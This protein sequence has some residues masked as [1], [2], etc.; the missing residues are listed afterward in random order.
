MITRSWLRRP[1]ARTAPARY[2]P[3]LE[4]LE[5][6]TLLASYV[7]MNAADLITDIR[8]TNAAGG[9]N[10]IELNAAPSAPY[11]L[12]AVN[13]TTDGANGLPVIAPGN[14]LI[15]FAI[16]GGA[17]I[18]IQRSTA[19]GTPAFRLFDVAAGARLELSGLTLKDGLA[20]GSG[21]SAEGGAIYSRGNLRLSEVTVQNNTAQGVNG[22]TGNDNPINPDGLPGGDA[23]GGGLYVAGG[24]ATL[25][26]D[27]I[28]GNSALGGA[29]G[30]GDVTLWYVA[31]E[32]GY[33]EGSRGGAGGSGYGGGLYVADGIVTLGNDG[34]T[35]TDTISGNSAQGGHG[36]AGTRNYN[37]DPNNDGAA[38][39]GGYGGGF[40]VAGGAVTLTNHTLSGNRAQGG[41]GG[42]LGGKDPFRNFPAGYA[43]NGGS[44]VGGGLD[45]TG[46][47]VA[48]TNDTLRGNSAKG[49]Y[50][51]SGGDGFNAD[52]ERFGANGVGGNG[53]AGAG[54]GLEVAGGTVRSSHD[55]LSG[56]K[57]QGGFGGDGGYDVADYGLSAMGGNGGGG[58]G[59]GL[60]VTGGTV[61][62]SNDTL[63]SN[64]AQGGT[65][66]TGGLGSSIVF[67]GWGRGGAGGQGS[68]GGLHVSQGTVT[69]SND[70]LNSNSAQ[71]GSGGRGALPLVF[72]PGFVLPKHGTGGA[73]GNGGGA[74]GGGLDVA[75]GTVTLSS[76]T[77]SGN[78]AQ[79][80]S[81]G[82]GGHTFST[83][84]TEPSL[85]GD[86]N[87]GGNGG[88]GGGGVG[89]GLD[90]T[91]GTVTLTN[92]TLSGN[93]A[94][95][96]TGGQG[97]FSMGEFG[98]TQTQTGGA[99]GGGGRGVG[100][101]LGVAG[102]AVT[103]TND[104]LSGNS[105]RAGSGGSGGGAGILT[106]SLS[107]IQSSG[108]QV[109]AYIS[110]GTGGAGG[111]AGHTAG[112]GLDGAGGSLTLG[113]TLIAQNTL[114]MGT[115][116]AGGA[117][118]GGAGSF[119]GASGA[120]GNSSGPDV[121]GS[122]TS[123]G[124]NLIGA[125][126]GSNLHDGVNG[127]RVGTSGRAIDPML[128]PLQNNGGPTLTM[129][130]LPNS[131]ALNTG[132]NALIRAGVITD[133]RGSG[134][135]RS[136]GG[137]VD[138]GAFEFQ[139]DPP[140]IARAPDL[141]VKEG[142]TAVNFAG[143]Y[144][145][146]GRD[147]VTVTASL[148]TV[149]QDNRLGGWVW[150]YTP[151]DGPA[152]PTTV[153]IT[154]TDDYGLTA[155]S[156]FLLTVDNVAPTPTITGAPATGHIPEGTAITLGSTVTDPSSVDTAAGFT[157][158][159]SMT[160]NG[161]DVASWSG[162]DFLSFAL[163]DNGTYVVTL[164]ATD[165]DGGV[166]TTRTTITVD[167]VAPT[168][169]V[170]GPTDGVR[171]Q[172]RTFTLTASDPSTFMDQAAGF[173]FAINWGDGSTQTVSGP[174]GTTVSHVYTASGGYTVQVT[175]TDKDQ[176][177]GAAVTA[178]DTI[179]AVALETDP[180]DPSQTAL[181]VGGTTGADTITI[182]PADAHGTL[183]VKIGN[184]DL[185]NFKPTGHLIVY[186][187]AGDDTLKLQPAVINGATVYVTAPALLFGDDGNDT[188]DA[189][190]SSANNVL[191]GGA[192]NDTLRG[193]SGRDLLV[194]GVGADLL[195]GDA[196]DDIL[197]GGTTDDDGN[198][199][200]LSAVMAEWS[201][202]DADDATRV[203]H[204]SGTLRGGLNGATLLTASTV[205][206]DAASDIL[207][208]E[209]GTDWFF[210]LL[211][212]TNQ[213]KVKDQTA[214][215]V[216]TGL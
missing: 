179:T 135:A 109:S 31:Q 7:A 15:I 28:S 216:V 116:G 201:R 48:L 50:G 107:D 192:G 35:N 11:T 27:T 143:F 177:T 199:S 97:G 101:G 154:A 183:D 92:D 20:A 102:G 45:V 21:V 93:S 152:G 111:G 190:D 212:G 120:S 126:T 33:A 112:G 10:T 151:P 32:R 53:G 167:N 40:Y 175:A 78:S 127:N 64:S 91:G 14:H 215:E 185:G 73:G 118:S 145:P 12:T 77:L 71:G 49:G 8:L 81:G 108:G 131:P 98:N 147:T 181:C 66:G 26:L 159:W 124:H 163:D 164:T 3:R 38:G 203:K 138:I 198:L 95:G 103:L 155:T 115:A 176:G 207:L 178:T 211:S 24:T 85:P 86:Y 209:G 202:T 61:L 162:V 141:T 16:F 65:G 129:A 106:R 134:F 121:C 110:G 148:G 68:G 42:D 184:T 210:A 204:L 153:T 41:G 137:T 214:G 43:G 19:P 39:G 132:S 5:A 83:N 30:R 193:G 70:T 188:L 58:Y 156:T 189:S 157:Y 6:R 84:G 208:G 117:G 173:T 172:A 174:S 96:G 57:A 113:N 44:G 104:T 13:N 206:D 74:Q 171:G 79:G 196:G 52:K 123:A 105:A 60:D 140:T 168:A 205:H 90:V 99:G 51:G 9:T 87:A 150:R 136:R 114:T 89:G 94:Q 166:G 17:G 67:F 165:K 200:A 182:K 37:R 62:S 186:G 139:D 197:I 56:N 194:G 133:Q 144:D 125:G 22:L 146:Q 122:V 75:G 4:A 55:T 76:D 180:T 195:R 170:S 59:G 63:S 100:G 47:S 82:D 23:R 72:F 36:G 161:V 69:L 80:G 46:G 142:T 187:Q 25:L 128:G 160:Q 130:L 1:F 29:G 191:E 149:T 54:G 34:T 158:H 18:T 213:D 88:N 169:D 119:P 2:R